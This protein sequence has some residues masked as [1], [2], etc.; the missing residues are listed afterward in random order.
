MRIEQLRER[1]EPL[2]PWEQ[3]QDAALSITDEQFTA[4]GWPNQERLIQALNRLASNM[5]G[6]RGSGLAQ[7]RKP[8]VKR[9]MQ[10]QR[11]HDAQIASFVKG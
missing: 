7:R 2:I 6:P 9:M 11:I 8:Y 3:L 10:L 1:S 5:E 4:L